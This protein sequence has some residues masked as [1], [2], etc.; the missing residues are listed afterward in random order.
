MTRRPLSS[1]PLATVAPEAVQWLWRHRIP[2]G[3]VTILQGDPGQG[4]GHVVLDVAARLT[5]GR[6]LPGEDAPQPLAQ[7]IWLA[8]ED[9]A[10]RALRPRLDAAGGDAALFHIV[11]DGGVPIVFPTDTSALAELIGRRNRECPDQPV[12][13]VVVDPLGEFKDRN[14]RIIDDAIRQCMEA[15]AA[16]AREHNIAVVVVSHLNKTSSQRVQ[17]AL[18][19]GGGNLSGIAGV[20]RSVFM[21]DRKSVV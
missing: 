17:S 5:T 7:V 18:H 15:L 10:A 21:V 6:P 20:V 1:R 12:R 4:K 2:L 13:L 11:D 8:N 3:E 9:D 16:V 19:R 14:L